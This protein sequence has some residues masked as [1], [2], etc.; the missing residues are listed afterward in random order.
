MQVEFKETLEEIKMEYDRRLKRI[1]AAYNLLASL[2]TETMCELVETRK[3][4]DAMSANWWW[5][6]KHHISIKLRLRK[7]LE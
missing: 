3:R 6:F 4:M 5:M 1:E 7:E 2:H